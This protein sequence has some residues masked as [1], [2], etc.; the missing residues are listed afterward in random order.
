MHTQFCEVVIVNI[1]L[2]CSRQ[3]LYHCE[4]VENKTNTSWKAVEDGEEI[5]PPI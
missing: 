5:W 4:F 3:M 1:A 2:N